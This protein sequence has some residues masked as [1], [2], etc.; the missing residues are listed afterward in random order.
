MIDTAQLLPEAEL[1]RLADLYRLEPNVNV[2]SGTYGARQGRE[3]GSSVEIQDFRDY[4][5]GDDPRRV[6]WVAY[7]RTGRMIVRLYREEV[8]PFFD[9]VVDESASMAIDDGRKGP[10]TMDLARWT[11]RSARAGGIAARAWAA[12]ESLRRLEDPGQLAFKAPQSVLFGAPRRAAAGLRRAA[13]RM[14]LSDFISPTAPSAVVKA[15]SAGC[16]RLIVV[17]VLGPWEADP[18]PLGPS[19]LDAVET[20]RR[21]DL[22]LDAPAVRDYNR[23]LAALRDDLRDAVFRCGGLLVE[24]VAEGDLETVLRE[25]FLPSG[26]VEV[27]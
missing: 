23:R 16:A 10:L 7:A 26:L 15:L 6:D 14:V 27:L 25:K 2:S 3:T 19:V 1:R 5:P 11:V 12:G 22:T 13:V 18:R 20:G 9:L 24:V 4:V 17:H 21:A 8:S